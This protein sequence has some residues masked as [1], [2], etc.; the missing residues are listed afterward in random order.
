VAQDR[1]FNA[2]TQ[3]QVEE[4][5]G[6]PLGHV[7]WSQTQSSGDG[8]QLPQRSLFALQT[9]ALTSRAAGVPQNPTASTARGPPGRAEARAHAISAKNAGEPITAAPNAVIP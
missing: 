6:D 2:F 7:Y 3:W 5:R 9:G 1:R 4:Y 8:V